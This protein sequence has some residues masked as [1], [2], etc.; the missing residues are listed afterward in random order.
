MNDRKFFLQ[1]PQGGLPAMRQRSHGNQQFQP[2]PPPTGQMP[3]HL[4]LG[5][6]LPP[7]QISQITASGSIS[8][9]AIGDTGGIVNGTPQQMVADAMEADY[10]SYKPAFFYHLGDLVYFYGEA[11]NYYAQFYGPYMHYPGP[12]LAIP[13][14]H[15]GDV[16][17]GSAPSLSAFV[18]NFCA[19]SPHLTPEAGEAPR[20]A[21]TQP[22]VYWTL[23]AP[24]VTIIGLYSNVPEG[25]QF[26]QDQLDWLAG[27]LR[28]APKDKALVISVHHP[29]YSADDE[30]GGSAVIEQALDG[31][32]GASGRTAD[33]VLTG[34]VHNYQ[35]FIRKSG[36]TGISYIVAGSGG[37][38]NLHKLNPYYGSN[39]QVP[40]SMPNVEGL[41][42]ENY[43]VDHFG[44][45]RLAVSRDSIDGQYFAVPNPWESWDGPYRKVDEFTITL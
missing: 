20:E 26:Q 29:A 37:Y 8:F 22:N 24:F 3:Y 14:N 1:R 36:G 30:H 2:L 23:D 34:H 18:E 40:F 38:H 15:D 4:S 43:C 13:G 10:G 41:T 33:L 12:I 6:I 31:A 9:H 45:M 39:V 21:M 35:R 32:F 5:D 11:S 25:G 42:L 17:V 7:E 16:T 28:S 27:E 44:F 19:K